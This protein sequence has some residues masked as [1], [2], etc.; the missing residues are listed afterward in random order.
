MQPCWQ[1]RHSTDALVCPQ[2]GAL[3]P[4]PHDPFRCFGLDVRLHLDLD[5][6]RQVYYSLSRR[7][8]PDF[9]SQ[10]SPEEQQIS[11]EN[12]AR[13]TVAYRTLK[14]PVLR[15]EFLV[16]LVEGTGDAVDGSTTKPT[17]PAELFDDIL[18]LEETL[19]SLATAPGEA[20]AWAN[21]RAAQLKFSE[22]EKAIDREMATLFSEW[23]ALAD[24]KRSDNAEPTTAQRG[25][26][27]RLKQT[28]SHRAY[29]ER[30][31]QRIATALAAQ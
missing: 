15:A 3:Q 19:A 1:C 29:L 25:C 20:A 24:R 31:R 26:V 9:Y 13:L 16:R 7:C 8:H 10:K 22:R 11:L 27:A 2:C 30:A 21:L 17:P 6:L 5:R 28:L 18:D 4:L 14:D 12:S 23:D